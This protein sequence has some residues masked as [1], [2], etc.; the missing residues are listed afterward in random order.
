MTDGSVTEV[1]HSFKVK[2]VATGGAF[3]EKMVEVKIV[4]CRHE[5]ITS[6]SLISRT[7]YINPT[8]PTTLD[9]VQMF[10]SNDTYC[11]VTSYSLTTDSPADPTTAS[12]PTAQ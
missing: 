6:G 3:I 5:M 12:A 7:V 11:P 4:V 1:I 10:S 9:V 2:A 8:T